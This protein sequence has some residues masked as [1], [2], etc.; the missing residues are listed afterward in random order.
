MRNIF[1]EETP[2][3][4]VQRTVEQVARDSYG[5]LLAFL[6]ARSRDFAAAEDALAE[7][8]HAAL[9]T[10]PCKGI[11]EKRE[12]WLLISARRR[13][14]DAARHARVHAAAVPGLMAASNAAQEAAETDTMFPDERLKLLFICAHPAISASVRTPLML[15]TVL[16]WM[17]R[18]SR[19]RFSCNLQPWGS[20]SA[21][22]KRRFATR[23]FGSSYPKRTSCHSA[24]I[25][26]YK[27][28]TPLTVADGKI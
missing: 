14:I 1:P 3:E 12:A 27:R 21:G 20:G 18:A 19:Q 28:S 2:G 23:A 24:W 16:G 17:L 25:P 10:W 4:E 8:F 9:E 13:P 22:R 15:Q 5:R 6:A 26:C 11:P 7:V